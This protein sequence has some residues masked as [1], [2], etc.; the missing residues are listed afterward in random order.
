MLMN[1][2]KENKTEK[3][4]K[5]SRNILIGL[6]GFIKYYSKQKTRTCRQ[7]YLYKFLLEIKK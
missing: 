5:T 2:E 1:I 6:F 7:F 3:T 4:K